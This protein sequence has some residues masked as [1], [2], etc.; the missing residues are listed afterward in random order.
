MKSGFTILLLFMAFAACAQQHSIIPHPQRLEWK[1]GYFT[2]NQCTHLQFDSGNKELQWAVAPLKD[3]LSKAAGLHLTSPVNCN[4]SSIVAV[5]LKSSI[6][7]EEGYVLDIS[8]DKIQ[9]TAQQPAGVFYAVQSLL[10]LLPV[11]VESSTR[12][13]N[14]KW[15]VPA[16]RI[17]DAP[18]F[19]Y[20]G[21]MLDVARHYMHL[22]SVKRFID[23]LARQ[24]A[25][26]FH[27][28]LTDSQGWRFE[29]KKWKK[30]NTIAAYRKGTPLN[31]T[32]DYN[33][34]PDDTLYGGY[35]TQ[36]QMREVVQYAAERF[37]TVVPEIE[38]PAHSRSALAAYPQ[39][40]CLD[41]NG[42]A[43]AYPQQIQDEYCT[44]DE[45]FHFLTD[46]LTEVMGV[47]P[48]PYIHIAGDEANKQAW[49][50]CPHDI[51]RM[52]E[53]GLKSVE[54]L[55]SYFVKRI[56]R[57]V[58]G[59]GRKVIGWDE[60]MEGGLAPGASVMS[61]TGIQNGIKAAQQGH[62]VVM[63]PGEYCY[64]DHYQSD[65]H[66]EPIAWGGLTTLEKVYSYN[67]LP[68]ALKE[69]EAQYILGAQGNLWT[70]FI[71]TAAKAEY[72][73]FPRAVALAEVAWSA[74]EQ[75][76]YADFMRRLVPY[77]QR[78]DAYNVNYARHLYSL[79]LKDSVNGKGQIFVTLSGAENGR[80]IYYTLDGSAPGAK[81]SIYK[82]PIPIKGNTQI[83][84]AVLLNG[85]VVAQLKRNF[86]L[87]KLTGKKTTLVESPSKQYSKGGA[88]AWHNGSPGSTGRYNDEEWLGWNGKPFDATIDLGSATTTTSLQTCFF[89]KPS[90]WI[91]APQRVTIQVSDDGKKFKTVAEQNVAAPSAEG[92]VAVQIS[93]MPVQAKWMRIVVTPYG[94]IPQGQSGAGRAAW[95]FVD[96]MIVE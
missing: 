82:T 81:S 59:K 17:E 27:W 42:N 65:A 94:T 33:S 5:A 78:L 40:A 20:R 2:F 85:H 34:R 22:D 41:S 79:K 70:E 7:N 62:N 54:E 49:R 11:Q 75:K 91:W 64:F 55:Q 71:P 53:E 25:N 29:S 37:I 96:E 57:F 6:T 89:H 52:Q 68:A 93:W 43:F 48:S 86:I 13:T 69:N 30:L 80:P 18:R 61:W 63:T 39:L 1:K 28:H 83:N 73:V 38:M 76:N 95:M 31:T 24:K 51:K 66:G 36:D 90:S 8:A 92:S 84:A 19:G 35:Y 23:L 56:S 74:P 60:I 12:V 32:Y 67:L 77:L 87:H 72:M 26:R 44:K 88:S 50:K 4:K 21:L 46:I 15:Q 47:F 16:M 14:M 10:Q 3:K 58:Q 9:I 45:T